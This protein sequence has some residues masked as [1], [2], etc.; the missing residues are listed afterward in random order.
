[1]YTPLVQPGEAIEATARDVIGVAIEVHRSLG[2]GFLEGVY[3]EAMC[4]ELARRSLPFER[5][6]PVLIKYKGRPVG[7]GR[8]DLV[9]ADHLIV[10]LKAVPQ[11]LPIHTAQLVSYLRAMDQPLGLLINFQVPLLRAG[12]RR[13]IRTI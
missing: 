3:E 8:L 2:S 6:V 5:Q 9:V 12:I 10:E 13:V 11:V 4:V 7:Q 1:V